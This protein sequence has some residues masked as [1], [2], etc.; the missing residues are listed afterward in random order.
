MGFQAFFDDS[1]SGGSPVFVLSGFVGPVASWERFSDEWQKLLDES[2]KLEYFKMREAAQLC[3][4]FAG[5]KAE[6]RNQR[7]Q[8]FFGVIRD[9]VHQ[10]ASCV[11][12]MEPFK[13][14]WKGNMS[15][16]KEWNDPYYVAIW[17]MIT[18]LT[19]QHNKFRMLEIFAK[20]DGTPPS[21]YGV[22]DFIFDDNPRLAAKVS[23]Y[24]QI[25]RDK[26]HP[27][28]RG[29]IGASPDFEDDKDFLPLQA[30]D[31]Q[32]WYFRRLFAERFGNEPFKEELPKSC[33]APLD[34]VYSMMSF[35]GPDRMRKTVAKAPPS[36]KPPRIFESIH[37][38]IANGDFGETK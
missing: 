17:D 6:E 1:G 20:K 8:K 31:A 21:A 14:I 15:G 24:Y 30:C 34:E 19:D 9:T 23:P 22:L 7:I 18:L 27:L 35:F 28:F 12:P 10:S 38:I 3:D 2:P 4:Q 26:M 16:E 29:W 13:R 33:F 11:I 37:D 32:S 25:V 5:M 36:K